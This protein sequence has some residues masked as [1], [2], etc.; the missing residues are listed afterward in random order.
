MPLLGCTPLHMAA[1]KGRADI[2]KIITNKIKG[3][4]LKDVLPQMNDGKT[5]PLHYAIQNGH[6]EIHNEIISYLKHKKIFVMD[7]F[8]LHHASLAFSQ[9]KKNI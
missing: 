9:T 8:L 2:F 3:C 7:K 1:N 6:E 5:T 4:Q